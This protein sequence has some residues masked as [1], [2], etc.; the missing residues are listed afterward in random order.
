MEDI[1]KA[2]VK[3]RNI[4]LVTIIISIILL[5]I[6]MVHYLDTIKNDF[7]IV[8]I[9]GIALFLAGILILTRIQFVLWT[10]KRVIKKFK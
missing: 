3:I 4:A 6:W 2:N 7:Q 9:L 10:Q 8:L 1:L 5:L